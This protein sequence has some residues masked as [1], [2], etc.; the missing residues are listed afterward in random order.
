M[1]G[2]QLYQTEDETRLVGTATNNTEQVLEIST[3]NISFYD[4]QGQILTLQDEPKSYW[5]G[6]VVLP[7]DTIPF[8][9]GL[10]AAE[11][12]NYE[13][14]IEAAPSQETARTDFT[15][16]AMEG[17]D[18]N[19]RYCVSGNLENTGADVDEYLIIAT[20]IY[21]AQEVVVNFSDYGVF[22][23]VGFASGDSLPFELCSP[24]LD[25][26][27]ARYEVLVWGK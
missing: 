2:V 13:V 24:T 14:M 11:V 18:Q 6:Y 8:E 21:D 19:E 9:V 7:G 15:L 5:P 25:Q 27:V 22:G 3:I 23:Y 26:G 1:A 10:E 4:A 17:R 12:A 20:I 16:S